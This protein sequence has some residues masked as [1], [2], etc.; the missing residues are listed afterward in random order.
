MK[1][2]ICKFGTTEPFYYQENDFRIKI[3]FS[4]VD[5]F[6][7]LNWIKCLNCDSITNL[8]SYK[9]IHKFSKLYNYEYRSK[10]SNE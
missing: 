10:L 5:E 2:N 3:D 7:P 8:T 1:C 6:Y 9:N 4:N